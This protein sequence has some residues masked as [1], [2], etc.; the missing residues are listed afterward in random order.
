MGPNFIGRDDS[1]LIPRVSEHAP[2]PKALRVL[3]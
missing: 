1:A 2:P 3:T